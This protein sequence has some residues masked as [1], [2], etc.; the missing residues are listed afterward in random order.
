VVLS[1]F[2]GTQHLRLTVEYYESSAVAEM[3]VELPEP[4]TL[5]LLALAAT[6]LGGYIRRRQAA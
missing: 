4:A 5:A 2:T 3:D 1:P 6:G